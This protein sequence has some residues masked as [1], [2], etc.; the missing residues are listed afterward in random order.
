MI[1]G[2][3]FLSE[4]MTDKM[5]AIINAKYGLDKPLLDQYLEYMGNLLRGDL[6]LALKRQGFT[7]HQIIA[8]KFPISAALGGI[9]MIWAVTLGILMGVLSGVNHNKPI[10]RATMFVCT[11]G[12]AVPSFV[13]GTMLLYSFGVNLNLLPTIGLSTPLHYI[14]PVIALSFQP[15]SYIAR[16]MRSNMLDAIDQDYIK[17]ARAK[18]LPTRKIIFKHALKNTILPVITYLGPMTAGVLTGGFVTENIFS[19]PGLGRYFV[20]SINNRDYPMIMGTTIFFAALIIVA[21]MLVDI[22]Y[23]VVDPRIKFD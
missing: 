14:M 11:L 6:G 19:V 22:L 13:I 16:L 5:L 21:N 18:G 12:I 2:G 3:P 23:R 1:P 10:D 9:T 17:T 15:M 8:E 4:K 20:S 7:V